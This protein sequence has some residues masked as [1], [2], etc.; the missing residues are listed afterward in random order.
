MD[1]LRRVARGETAE[2]FGSVALEE[3]RRWRRYGFAEIAKKNFALLPAE[4]Q[5]SLRRYAEGVNAFISR[6]DERSL[7]VEF[8]ILQYRPRDWA[9]EDT[10][11]IGK[12]L[13]DALSTTWRSDL[14][15]AALQTLPKEKYRDLM[16]VKSQFDVILFGSDLSDRSDS[17]NP[18]IISPKSAEKSSKL[19]LLST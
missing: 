5:R 3:D 17:Q 6:L 2:I 7:P 9:V 13:A 8:R 10:I 15:N 1:L 19:P 14:L 16:N 4:I 12:I 11:V 18:K